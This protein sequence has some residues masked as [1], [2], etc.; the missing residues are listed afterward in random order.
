MIEVS[1][2]YIGAAVLAQ[3]VCLLEMD[4]RASFLY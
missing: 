3:L 2:L 1:F 4:D